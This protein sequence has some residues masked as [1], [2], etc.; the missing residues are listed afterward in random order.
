MHRGRSYARDGRSHARVER[1]G[2][3]HTDPTSPAVYATAATGPPLRDRG[4]APVA[5]LA[6]DV[7]TLAMDVA[8]L[9]QSVGE[10]P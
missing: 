10:S 3:A 7:A 1:G 4:Y 9:A 8:T 6:M 2:S 5:A